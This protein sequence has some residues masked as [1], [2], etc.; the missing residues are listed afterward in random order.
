[1]LMKSA[2]EIRSCSIKIISQLGYEISSSLPLLEFDEMAFRDPYEVSRRILCLHAV[3]ALSFDFEARQKKVAEWLS[4]EKLL[5]D[6]TPVESNLVFGAYRENLLL[7]HRLD[8]L[9]GLAW[10]CSLLKNS[11]LDHV[12]DDF[13]FLFPSIAKGESTA[14]FGNKIQLTGLDH[15]VGGLDL[16]Y[17]LDSAMMDSY[18]RGNYQENLI[19][20]PVSVHQRRHAL[21]WLVSDSDWE[22]I[23]LDT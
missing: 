20:N 16:L 6:L 10:A 18:L 11:L 15:L 1:M 14:R 5:S 4:N 2:A 13:V 12:P 23:L 19:L 7:A 22:T 21:E 8:A 17:C 9:F 3:I